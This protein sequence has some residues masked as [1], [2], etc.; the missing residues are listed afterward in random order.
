VK[1]GATRLTGHPDRLVVARAN[2]RDVVLEVRDVRR[3]VVDVN[4]DGVDCAARAGLEERVEPGETT[5][6]A[7]VGYRG[8]DELQLPSVLS[9][10]REPS[11]TIYERE[12]TYRLHVSLPRSSG[13]LRREVALT[14]VI[15]LV[16]AEQVL[17][18]GVNRILHVG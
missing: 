12:W 10:R 8:A 5:R 3:R 11:E 15:G 1:E 2:T 9:N 18:A 16:K 6:C 4:G 14:R 17:G 7:C 13:L